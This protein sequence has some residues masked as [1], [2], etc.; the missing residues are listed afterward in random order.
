MTERGEDCEPFLNELILDL[1][2]PCHVT[3][4]G[5]RALL[6]MSVV[7]HKSSGICKI[8]AWL[9]HEVIPYRLPSTAYAT[10][11]KIGREALHTLIRY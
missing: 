7:L 1:S 4:T 8:E 9:F 11:T 2:D 10:S 5:I 3:T 6:D